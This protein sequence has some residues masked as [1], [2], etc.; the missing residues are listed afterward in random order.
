LRLDMAVS[1]SKDPKAAARL[2]G[3]AKPTYE[4]QPAGSPKA[5]VAPRTGATDRLAHIDVEATGESRGPRTSDSEWLW[6]KQLGGDTQTSASQILRKLGAPEFEVEDARKE[7]LRIK[8][9]PGGVGYDPYNQATKP[10][11]K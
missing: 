2:A 6:R 11:R 9:E 7:K 3:A 5:P 1:D 4:A 10:R 8:R